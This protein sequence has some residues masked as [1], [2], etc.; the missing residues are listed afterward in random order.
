MATRKSATGSHKGKASSK[1]QATRPKDNLHKS[2]EQADLET[3]TES[4]LIPRDGLA[5]LFVWSATHQRYDV[6]DLGKKEEAAV[7]RHLEVDREIACLPVNGKLPESGKERKASQMEAQLE[8]HW[9]NNERMKQLVIGYSRTIGTLF[10]AKAGELPESPV[11]ELE[12]KI[13]AM[14][15]NNKEQSSHLTMLSDMLEQ[16]KE[17]V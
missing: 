10:G 3:S 13:A 5:R 16:L 2:R 1:G 17:L 9:L 8:Q 12:N 6:I 11:L 14:S 15:V 7:L 4:I